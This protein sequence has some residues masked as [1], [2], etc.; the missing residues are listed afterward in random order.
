M[1]ITNVTV[2]TLSALYWAATP[3]ITIQIIRLL[4][5]YHPGHLDL[6]RLHWYSFGILYAIIAICFILIMNILAFN[7][8]LSS[9]LAKWML[10]GQRSTGQ[11]DWDKS[12][13]NQRWQVHRTL[14]ILLFAGYGAEGAVAPLSGSVYIVW[15]LR[16]FGAK[17]GKNCFIYAGHLNGRISEP[18]LIEVVSIV[19]HQR[20][21]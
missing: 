14:D 5:V 20:S 1:L 8:M 7:A 12:S 16:A 17:I 10:I 11:Y 6:S 19:L 9:I 15:Y 2:V 13:Y 3:V 18:D 4:V 21:T